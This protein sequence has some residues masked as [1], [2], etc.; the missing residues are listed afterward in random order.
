MTPLRDII[1]A[2]SAATKE[3]LVRAG[4]RKRADDNFTLDLDHRTQGSVALNRA[5]YHNRGPLDVNP[6]IGIRDQ[7]VERLLAELLGER[8]HPYWPSTVSRPLGYLTPAQ[9]IVTWTFETLES[10]P[11]QAEDMTQ[12]ILTYGIPYMKESSS[13]D[14][15]IE[16]MRAQPANEMFRYRLPLILWLEGSTEEAS[17]MVDRRMAEVW[18]RADATAP[19]YR[20][21][22]D[23]FRRLIST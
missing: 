12:A 20:R 22:A 11:M 4:F 13:R 21:F 14:A 23:R 16:T 1:A 7:E 19:H 17:A 15:F 9:W 18:N 6:V 8:F 5:T 3:R 2:M 10:V